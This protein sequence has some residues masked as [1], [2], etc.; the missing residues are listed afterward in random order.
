MRWMKRARRSARGARFV[1]HADVWVGGAGIAIFS[2]AAQRAPA[3]RASAI[4]E[5]S[6][7][8][9]WWHPSLHAG[10]DG[11]VGIASHAAVIDGAHKAP[12]EVNF[13]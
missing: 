12:R 9:R 13:A 4:Q 7:A 11:A 5:E 10:D 2:A 3:W 6:Q 1:K 8:G